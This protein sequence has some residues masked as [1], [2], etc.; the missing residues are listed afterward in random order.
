MTVE[1]L[2]VYPYIKDLDYLHK[3]NIKQLLLKFNEW[4]FLSILN[5][6]FTFGGKDELIYYKQLDINKYLVFNQYASYSSTLNGFDCR[7]ADFK[8]MGKVG[9]DEPF[10]STVVEL[11]FNIDK[12]LE[13]IGKYLGGFSIY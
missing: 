8:S 10:A 13:L 11:N 5:Q 3:F 1:E 9:I 7:I 12:D 4:G 6:S 2:H